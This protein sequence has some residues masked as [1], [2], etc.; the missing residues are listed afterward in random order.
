MANWKKVI[1]SGSNAELRDVSASTVNNMNGP[2]SLSITASGHW[3]GDL[4]INDSLV[5]VVVYDPSDGQ[6][7]IKH[8][9]DL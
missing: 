6:M 3:H 9:D 5:Y 4:P 8:Q 1:V 7:Y 2:T